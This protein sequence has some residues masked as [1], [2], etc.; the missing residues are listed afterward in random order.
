MSHSWTIWMNLKSM[1]AKLNKW[2]PMMWLSTCLRYASCNKCIDHQFCLPDFDSASSSQV[3][4][5]IM[6]IGPCGQ[7]EMGEP[8]FLSEE[9]SNH[10]DPDLELVTTSG[11][12]K[13]GAISVLQVNTTYFIDVLLFKCLGNI[14]FFLQRNIRPQVVTTFELPGCFDMWTVIGSRDEQVLLIDYAFMLFWCTFNGKWC[15]L[16]VFTEHLY[17]EIAWI[18]CLSPAQSFWFY[19]GLLYI[20]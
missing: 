13:N 18:S 17:R 4:D 9:F 20:L 3:C 11:Y 10:A 6:N 8:A 15:I 5:S 1:V 12:G 7:V 16:L 14:S 2:P 19:Y